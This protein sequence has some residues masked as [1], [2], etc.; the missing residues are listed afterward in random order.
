[1][2]LI[3]EVK[4]RVISGA[5][6]NG[7]SSFRREKYVP[8]G[9]PNG[10]DGGRGGDV[11]LVATRDKT[12][13]LDFKYRPKFEAERGEH[14]M[15]KDMYG[16]GGADLKIPVPLGTLVYDLESNELLADLTEHGREYLVAKG[17]KG[18]LGNIHFTTSTNRAPRM[19]TPGEAGETREL[20][21]ELRVLADVG[22]IGLP[23]AGKSSFLSAVSRA[24]PKIADYPFTT[25]EP[26]LG[27]VEHKGQAFVIADLPGLIE[28]A[29]EGIGLGH[30]FLRHVARNRVLLHLV[31]V[32][33]APKAIAENIAIIRRELEKYDPD[34]LQ[35][36]ELL[37]FTKIDLLTEGR[38]AQKKAALEKAGLRGFFVSSHTHAGVDEL[39]DRLSV[40]AAKWRAE[41][42][43]EGALSSVAAEETGTASPA[44][45]GHE[46]T[47]AAV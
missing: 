44:H 29:S 17:G 3:D 33:A 41:N 36:E 21:L 14:G 13:L 6:G 30:K 47:G 26:H 19:A 4:I 45:A 43:A 32:T 27:V 31:E 39:L 28:G 10:G 22:L 5:G 42:V 24:R 25:L 38:L 37:V 15:G 20:K 1:M 9:G 7:C 23:N 18:G 2:A 8:F 40:R 12:S 11:Y 46:R 34:L 35:R 16:R